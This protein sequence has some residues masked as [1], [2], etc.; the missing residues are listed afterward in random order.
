MTTTPDEFYVAH[1]PETIFAGRDS[2][3]VLAEARKIATPRQIMGNYMSTEEI[4][5]EQEHTHKD[6]YWVD[7]DKWEIA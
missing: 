4:Q 5:E 2:K 1:T 3:P 7:D 6:L